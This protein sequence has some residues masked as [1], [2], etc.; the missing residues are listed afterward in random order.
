MGRSNVQVKPHSTVLLVGHCA[1]LLPQLTTRSMATNQLAF[2]KTKSR[3]C[4]HL[5]SRLVNGFHKLLNGRLHRLG[6][7]GTKVKMSVALA[8]R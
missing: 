5:R 4:E 1:R 6:L 7:V 2:A 3:E 8:S